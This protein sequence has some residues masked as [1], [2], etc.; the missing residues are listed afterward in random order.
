MASSSSTIPSYTTRSTSGQSPRSRPRRYPADRPTVAEIVT[1]MHQAGDH[2]SGQRLRALISI[3][4]RA[5]LRIGEALE[6]AETDLDRD[7]GAAREGW[8]AA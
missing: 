5:G 7:R 1:V 6:L 8:Q 4:W 2:P 3:L